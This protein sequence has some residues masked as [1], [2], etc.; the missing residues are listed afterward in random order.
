MILAVDDEQVFLLAI[1]AACE[2]E[3]LDVECFLDASDALARAAEHRPDLVISDVMMPGLDGYAFKEALEKLYPG[4]Q[5]PFIFLSSRSA[6]EDMVRGLDAGAGDY[7]TKPIDQKLL[8][9]KIR[10]FIRREDEE[11]SSVFHG[12]LAEFP[13]QRILG[14]CEAQGL[15]GSVEFELEGKAVFLFFRQGIVDLA[16]MAGREDLLEKISDL[17]E[18]RFVI[19]AQGGEFLLSCDPWPASADDGYG[20]PGGSVQSD[21]DDKLMYLLRHDGLTGLHNRLRLKEELADR[22][23]EAREQGKQLAVLVIDLDHF[24]SVNDGLGHAVGDLLLKQV[25]LRLRS[26]LREGEGLYRVGGD[27][28]VVVVPSLAEREAALSRAECIREQLNRVFLLHERDLVISASIGISF[29][30]EHGENIGTLLSRA[31]FAMYR[32]KDEGRNLCRVFAPEMN[33]D[34]GYLI[35][36]E[37]DLRNA[38]GRNEFQLF[39]QPKVDLESQA[40]TGF[41]ALL[42]WRKPDG[43]SVSPAL[44]VPLAEQQGLMPYLDRWVLYAACRQLKMWH[45]AGHARLRVSV[46]ISAE[47]FRQAKDLIDLVEE[48]LSSTALEPESLLLEITETALLRD[49]DEALKTMQAI[50]D[51]GVSF[52]MDDFGTGYSSLSLVRRLPFAELKVDKSFIDDVPHD[53]HGIS[54]IW[55]TLSMAQSLNM[56][57]VAEGIERE[58]QAEFLRRHH[59]DLGQGF[60]FSRALS[61]SEIS[62]KLA[63]HTPLPWGS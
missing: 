21:P 51:L 52:S 15:T 42:R 4:R 23:R 5:P 50:R 40:V 34:A 18:G 10:S 7:L 48:V 30:P 56:R 37:S 58:E 49:V 45:E 33:E 16:P 8:R 31:D 61:A 17:R 24:R 28:F 60:L 3:G 63:E 62:G 54:I 47:H 6:T 57:V 29:F 55:A 11:R 41:E 36:L 43:S 9:A 19:R 26:C 44:F 32:A 2:S 39:Y 14:F 59:C 35:H 25:A 22:L 12:N 13:L 46:N 1:E 53:H 20:S 27:D 38:I